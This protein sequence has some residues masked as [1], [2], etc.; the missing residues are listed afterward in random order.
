MM[1]S[2][3]TE[4][5]N[6]NEMTEKTLE[7]RNGATTISYFEQGEGDTTL[8]FVHGWCINKGYW[9]SQMD[10]FKERYKVIA[11]DLP[12]FG[13][14]TATRSDWTIEQYSEDV[15]G[16]LD[17][18]NLTNV[19][20]VG[21][22]MAGEIVLEAAL[23]NHPSIVGLVGI[24]NFK[25]IDVQF[26]QE[27]LERMNSFVELLK[28]DFSTYAPVFADK[29]LFHPSTDSTVKARIKQDFSE[30]DPSVGFS[31]ISNLFNYGISEPAKLEQLNYKLHLINSDFMPANID[32]LEKHCK[33]S[34]TMV[35]IYETGHYPMIEKPD[36][37][38]ELLAGIIE[39]M[40]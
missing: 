2:R 28:K 31:S 23:K 16:I 29:M 20:L 39:G 9:K 25:T 38:N 34:F 27:Q 12:G 33:R 35:D 7:I 30:S 24:D 1:V 14:S 21:H 17:K 37:F 10:Y 36:K 5:Q 40:E 15:I 11:I 6:T 3:K 19:V 13:G 32:G 22:S 4:G 18:L 26:S 8:F